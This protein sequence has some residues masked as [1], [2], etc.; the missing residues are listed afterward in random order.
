MRPRLDSDR[1]RLFSLFP[2]LRGLPHDLAVEVDSRLQWVR[3]PAGTLLFDS[4]SP[5]TGLPLVL[6]GSIRVGKRSDS[7]REI[8]LYRVIPGEICLISLS[9]LLGGDDYAA[10]GSAVEPVLL[11]A[12]PKP[13]FTR[14]ME[15]HPPL[16][17]MVFH[18]Y[19]E[20]LA[21]LMQLIEEVAFRHLDERL[22]AWLVERGPHIHLSHQA[23]AQELGSVREIVSRL[24]KQFEERGWVRLDRGH[25]EVLDPLGL[26]SIHGG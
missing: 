19:G 25:V 23:I 12:L 2:A 4:G 8:G 13:L 6:E 20:R 16:R 26:L 17:E 22:A 7:G 21:A 15:G 9:C 10:T 5:C 3:V 11:A 24:L 18:L 14:L 1:E